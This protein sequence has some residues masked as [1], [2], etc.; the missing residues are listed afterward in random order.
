[1]GK[2]RSG[3]V[4]HLKE[5]DLFYTIWKDRHCASLEM[6]LALGWMGSFIESIL[7]ILTGVIQTV[8]KKFKL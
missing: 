6:A 5:F 1:M 4:V 8:V 3:F 7:C 2:M